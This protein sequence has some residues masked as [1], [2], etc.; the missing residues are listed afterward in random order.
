MAQR[1]DRRRWEASPPDAPRGIA[2][3]WHRFIQD[4]RSTSKSRQS[5]RLEAMGFLMTMKAETSLRKRAIELTG[6]VKSRQGHSSF[7]TTPWGGD[8]PQVR[9]AARQAAAPK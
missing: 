3:L 5:R 2:R 1:S 8:R 4:R 7:M 6:R 9:S